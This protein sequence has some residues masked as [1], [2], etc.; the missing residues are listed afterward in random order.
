MNNTV[1]NDFL[2]ISQSKVATV[3]TKQVRWANVYAIDVKFSQDLAR[4]KSLKSVNFWQNDL[5]N[6][7]VD[8]F[9][10]QCI[11]LYHLLH[12]QI[13]EVI[14]PISVTDVLKI[15][16]LHAKMRKLQI[17]LWR[18]TIIELVKRMFTCDA[19]KTHCHSTQ[20]NTEQFD[21]QN[22]FSMSLYTGV[23]NF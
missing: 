10:T 12:A 6:K 17:H 3:Y 9:R 7:K 21:I 22:G 13:K 23:T 1:K 20:K 4:E 19:L 2:W 5:K 16:S 15:R 11:I 18:L 14:S 8:V